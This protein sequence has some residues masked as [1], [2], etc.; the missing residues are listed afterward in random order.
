MFSL[1][2]QFKGFFAPAEN[3][4]TDP[5]PFFILKAGFASRH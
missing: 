1:L 5:R 3:R 2:K 4:S